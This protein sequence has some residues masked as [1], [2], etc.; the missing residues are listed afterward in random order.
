MPK[1]S[2]PREI[3]CLAVAAPMPEDAPVMSTHDF[4]KSSLSQIDVSILPSKAMAP[5][6]ST[7]R[8]NAAVLVSL[9]WAALGFACTEADPPAQAVE[10][11]DKLW[12]EIAGEPFELELA[13][14]PRARYRGL[15]GR[16]SIARNGGMLF[17]NE[18]PRPQAMVMRDCPI[19]IDVAF[20]DAA[21]RVVSIHEMQPEP[22]RRSDESA[23]EYEARLT[24]YPSGAP[25]GFAIEIAGGRFRELGVH[26]G[27]L[28]VFDVAGLRKRARQILD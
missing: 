4:M 27:D 19:A 28:V 5:I 10:Q 1:T 11:R 9:G 8:L 15:S 25:T 12:V 23:A 3:R 7:V 13:L 21:G 24:L 17:V 14:D 22:P 2:N 26:V 16:L 20:L 18:N 6:R